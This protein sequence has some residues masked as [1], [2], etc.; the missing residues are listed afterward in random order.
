MSK[1]YGKSNG[2]S[3]MG[4]KKSSRSQQYIAQP[5]PTPQPTAIPL[6]ENEIV[7][8]DT[9]ITDDNIRQILQ[10]YILYKEYIR[11]KR[12]IRTEQPHIMFRLSD[13]D[14]SRITNMS[15]LF[16][17]YAFDNH[18]IISNWNVSNVTDMSHMFEN[19]NFNQS[20]I[21]SN[22]TPWNVSA[23][24]NMGY[25]FLKCHYFNQPF[26]N[27]TGITW[28]VSNVINMTGMFALCPTFNQF[29]G[30]WNVSNV[31]TM[32]RMFQG[33][34]RFKNGGNEQ[35]NW[36]PDRLQ[37]IANMFHDAHMFN[38]KINEWHLNINQVVNQNIRNVDVFK[39]SQFN[40]S[41]NLWSIR[42][43][44]DDNMDVLASFFGTDQLELEH[45]LI[46]R[47]DNS[48]PTI[49]HI[50]EVV[51]PHAVHTGYKT[52]YN[53][54]QIELIKTNLSQLVGKS[55]IF[56]TSMNQ[57]IFWNYIFDKING[58]ISSNEQLRTYK[59]Y[60][61]T[62]AMKS[63]LTSYNMLSDNNKILIGLCIDYTFNQ[64]E[65][66]IQEY[67]TQFLKD[68]SM[69]YGSL[70]EFDDLSTE[71]DKNNLSCVNGILERFLLTLDDILNQVCS[72]G[73]PDGLCTEDNMHLL[74]TG[75]GLINM[76]K[77]RQMITE[78]GQMWGQE[79]LYDEEYKAKHR[80]IENQSVSEIKTDFIN[81][82]T[83][84]IEQ[85]IQKSL[86]T[87][88]IDKINEEANMYE[89]SGIFNRM[90]FGGMQRK[91]NIT[92]KRCKKYKKQNK[93]NKN[94][95]YKKRNTNKRHICKKCSR[96]TNKRQ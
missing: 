49:I 80:W 38:C 52:K 91:R 11:Q 16:L 5:P 21:H 15:K 17:G 18:D 47:G 63:K 40:Q 50:G 41:L 42:T 25:M 89:E 54:E 79:H 48:V 78:Y 36:H 39:N 81:Y 53:Y 96:I 13:W 7:S 45:R 58:F 75:F 60:E 12:V 65:L 82:I 24:T 23:V 68:N 6:N 69:A 73:S 71:F 29:I 35:M 64:N 27:A 88:Y 43:L 67:V 51:D 93:T 92:N 84:K 34:R 70:N 72:T 22:G 77:L 46:T 59:V 26:T 94:K 74:E 76:N 3:D 62:T 9:I 90:S 56:Y 30:N 19:S 2:D 4:Y 31:T 1:K 28:N 66:F 61:I 57:Y 37:V 33:A 87:A 83:Q 86:P 10:S 55:A 32:A 8:P 85:N 14:V 20:L 95:K 44:E